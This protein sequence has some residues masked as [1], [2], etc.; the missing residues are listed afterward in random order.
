MARRGDGRLVATDDYYDTACQAMTAF[1]VEVSWTWAGTITFQV[2]IGGTWADALVYSTAHAS[3]VATTTV[4]VKRLIDTM[5]CGKVR[6]FMTSWTS[7]AAVI[8]FNGTV[9]NLTAGSGSVGAVVDTEL[10]AAVLLSD[11]ALADPVTTTYAGAL[12]FIYD[13]T[14]AIGWVRQRM[15]FN[16]TDAIAGGAFIS[17]GQ[18]QYNSGESTAGAFWERAR[19]N[20]NQVQLASAARTAS[21]NGT[22]QTNQNG[23]GIMVFLNVSASAGGAGIQI[24]IEMIDSISGNTKQISVSPTAV[25][26]TGQYVYVYYPGAASAGGAV[27]TSQQPIPRSWRVRV[28]HGDG[29]SHTYSVSASVNV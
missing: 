7:G 2:E 22:T 23:R 16:V 9:G 21:V 12:S 4:N 5:G 27:S 8:A 3:V 10:P 6:A 14:S 20:Y 15:A 1:G 13:P 18:M 19:G 26:A 17:T 29:A 28:I 24:V 11:T 25:T